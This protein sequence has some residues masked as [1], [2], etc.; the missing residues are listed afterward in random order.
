MK[1]LGGVTYRVHCYRTSASPIT[2]MTSDILV[3]I[4]LQSTKKIMR[5]AAY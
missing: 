5:I 2:G 4:L 3:R 1:A